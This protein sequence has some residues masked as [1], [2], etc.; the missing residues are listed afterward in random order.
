MNA[1][2]CPTILIIFGGLP[3]AGKTKI[4]RE[5][6][7]QLGAVHVRIESFDRAL[8]D[9]G[10]LKG[11]MA[12]EGH[13]AAYAVAEDNLRLGLTVVADSVNPL[14]TTREAWLA[15]AKRAQV[16]AME[17][18]V[19]CSD[20]GEHRRRVETR[21]SGIPGLK[22]PTWSDVITRE[23]DPWDRS[24]LVIDT[25]ERSVDECVGMI[26]AAL[27]KLRARGLRRVRDDH[28][29]GRIA[30]PASTLAG[31]SGARRRRA[32]VASKIAFAIAAAVG[33]VAGSPAPLGAI[34]GWFSNTISTCAGT[35]RSMATG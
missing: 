8:R 18:E 29:D 31:V 35:S 4:A 25:A 13:R 1:S 10:R 26:R 5:L 9:S 20:A 7:R 23:Y 11:A 32:P 14:K 24:H 3:G 34:S 28:A 17:I 15:V 27:A 19:I 22:L 21:A 12:D 30:R 16:S 33:R 6:A 2:K